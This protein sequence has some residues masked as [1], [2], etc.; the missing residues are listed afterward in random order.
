MYE[1]ELLNGGGMVEKYLID[2]SFTVKQTIEK[3]EKDLIKAVV[4]VDDDKHVLGLF[5][6]GDM[7]R[8]FFAGRIPFR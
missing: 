5:S 4:V 8:F 2:I 7:R 3:M 1:M 6:N